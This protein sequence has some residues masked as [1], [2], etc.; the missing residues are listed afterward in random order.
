M[1]GWFK[2]DGFMV[3]RTAKLAAV[4]AGLC[5][6]VLGLSVQPSWAED[7]FAR[8]TGNKQGPIPGD[9]PDI[10]GV[11]GSKD[12]IR[13]FSTSFGLANTV[14]IGGGGA[15]TGKPVPTPVAL[16]KGFDRASPKLLQAAFLGEALTVEITWYMVFQNVPRKTVTIKLDGAFITNIEAAADL[17][18]N[19]ASGFE[20]VSL[21]YSRITFATPILDATGNVIGTSSVCLDVVNNITC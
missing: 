11:A 16:V 2:G 21:N 15:G 10:K 19:N 5:A 1:A 20:S 9:H 14:I 4:A 17:Q 8:I 12:A 3:M 7:A 18:G 6:V 13:V